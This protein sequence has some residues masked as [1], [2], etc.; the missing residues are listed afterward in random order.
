MHDGKT[1][2]AWLAG[3]AA[4][5]LAAM[6]PDV[7]A[8]SFPVTVQDDRGIAVT[9]EQQPKHVA[10]LWMAAADMLVALDQPVLGITT[11][12]GRRPVY[13][14]DA[15]ADAI[16]LGDITAP[17]LELMSTLDIDLTAGMT[18]YNAPYA[19]EIEK[20][21]GFVTFDG[22][23]LDT[24]LS[25]IE[26]LGAALGA[27]EKA[28]ALNADFLALADELAAQAPAEPRS[29]VFIWSFQDTLYGYQDNILTAQLIGK[30]GTRN[31]LGFNED[32]ET[33]DNAFVV[34][35]AEDL[36]A[37]DPDV[38]LMHISHGGAAK[39]NP[40]YE[41][42]KAYKSGRIYSVGHQYSQPSG[43]IARELVLREAAHLIYPETFPA[44]DMPDLARATPVEFAR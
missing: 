42:L 41:R 34:L 15:V 35:E 3:G 14:G 29:V 10:A 21:G 1:L 24:S 9:I 5:V 11:Y 43:P 36:L 16:D 25:A 44:P 38:I 4:L 7:Q 6:A 17:N 40:A 37:L 30:L 18:H 31:P 12:E 20:F 27:V 23:D 13:L 28:K 2:R 39:H 32:A 19:E 33:P 22:F 8:G 26:R